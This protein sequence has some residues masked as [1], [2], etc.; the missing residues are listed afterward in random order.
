[1]IKLLVNR[2]KKRK[3]IVDINERKNNETAK[4]YE[5]NSDAPI[6][7]TVKSR[8]WCVF[9][10]LSFSSAPFLLGVFL[11]CICFAFVVPWFQCVSRDL[12]RWKEVAGSVDLLKATRTCCSLTSHIYKNS[13]HIIALIWL[14]LGLLLPWFEYHTP[15]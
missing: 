1:M 9:W 6:D 5:C 13:D 4:Q 2:L 14:I 11:L 10:F 3:R 12:G 7:G 15:K 8:T